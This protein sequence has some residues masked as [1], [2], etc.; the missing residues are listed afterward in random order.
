MTSLEYSAENKSYNKA[1]KNGRNKINRSQSST[2]F[3]LTVENISKNKAQKC[4][5]N[6]FYAC[7]FTKATGTFVLLRTDM[8]LS[9]PTNF[10]FVVLAALQFV[11]A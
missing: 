3:D 2:G 4:Y 7:I 9:N 11:N 5:G 8:I 10:R 6:S 1:G